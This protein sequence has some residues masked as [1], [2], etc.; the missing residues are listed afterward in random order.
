MNTK[1]FGK[2]IEFVSTIIDRINKHDA[3]GLAAQLA[4]FF[5][6]SIFPLIIFLSTLIPYLPIDEQ[7][8]LSFLGTFV[9]DDSMLLIESHLDNIM[10]GNAKLLSF[11]IIGTLWSASNGM[12]ALLKAF[13]KAYDIPD[14]RKYIIVRAL[15][16]VL[17]IGMIFVFIIALL[18]PIFG[19]QIGVALF[20]FLGL[21]N[22]FLHLWDAIRWLLTL[23]IL[24]T[25]FSTLY[26]IFP[27]IKL[28]KRSVMKGSLFATL[29]W[30]ATSLGFSYFVN[31]FGNYTTTYGSLGGVIV[32]MLWFY[33]S[34][35]IIIL[36][37]E[38]N[39]IYSEKED[40]IE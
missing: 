33:L 28:K 29:G 23:F 22:E 39:A 7:Y 27:V 25:V 37:G 21:N 12:N 20:S 3:S 9:P 10:Q 31:N 40:S 30:T 16:M 35:H 8:I 1:I 15:A 19:K 18:L 17:T 36:G 26:W 2:Q 32:L 34:A 4:F 13:D 11:G 24:L 14:K 6:L 38:I 5:L